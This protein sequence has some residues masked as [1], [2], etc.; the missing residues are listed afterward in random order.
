MLNLKT[1]GV[2]VEEITRLPYSVAL[3]DTA[4]PT[5]IGYTEFATVGYNKPFKI[6]SFYNMKNI[7]EKPKRKYSVKRCKG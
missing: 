7:L 2:S 3:A 1:P 4:I 5:F 6:S